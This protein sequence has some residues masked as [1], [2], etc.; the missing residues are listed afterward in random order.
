MDDT[1]AS[2]YHGSVQDF[3]VLAF[4]HNSIHISMYTTA[5]VPM[6]IDC[7]PLILANLNFM[8]VLC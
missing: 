2:L 1:K 3:K 6:I 5:L 8:H 4:K 7:G